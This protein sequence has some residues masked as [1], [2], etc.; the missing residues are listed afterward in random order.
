[1]VSAEPLLSDVPATF[2]SA[3]PLAGPSPKKARLEL[4]GASTA[5]DWERH[6]TQE[7][8][9]R[10]QPTLRKLV[11]GSASLPGV[12]G[13]HGGLPHPS[14]FPLEG[15][16][17]NLKGG[18][19]LRI[20]DPQTVTAAQQYNMTMQGYDPLRQWVKAHTNAQHHPPAS[21][22][23]DVLIT[24]GS[25]HTLE[26]LLAM[27]VGPGGCLLC[28][29]FTY[30]HVVESVGIPLGIRLHGVAMD[31]DGLQPDSLRQVLQGVK[32][33]GAALPKVLY[34]I[35]TGQNPT[36]AIASLER[37]KAVYQIC[38]QED[39][40]ILED[41]PYYY[42]QFSTGPGEQPGLQSLEPS[43]LSMDVDGRVARLDTFSK[44]LVPGL[45]L[46]WLTAHP[47][48][49]MKCCVTIQGATVGPP[50]IS[51]VITAELMMHWDKK[52]ELEAQMKHIQDAIV[53]ELA[54]AGIIV[55]PG[56]VGHFQGPCPPGGC[57]C[58]R[59][60]YSRATDAELEK[61]ITMLAR[62]LESEAW[63]KRL[64]LAPEQLA[65]ARVPPKTMRL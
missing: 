56:R 33:S 4:P 24:N 9:L 55:L 47:T 11:T 38:Q 32:D 16:T 23:H 64:H 29:E 58:I 27:L 3:S 14:I 28:E 15:I 36:G 37:K 40:I 20:N 43:Y 48:L 60:S 31:A 34:T 30:P 1:M 19:T 52:H 44:F 8:K 7:A 41:D 53:G 61:G 57:P 10:T 54:D 51:Q 2:A 46:G 65:T 49:L 50:G 45:R 25:N 5:I 12:V 6:L 59:M 63:H 26:V 42:L 17:L 21:G 13:L 18:A 22:K 39:I 35:P 62:I